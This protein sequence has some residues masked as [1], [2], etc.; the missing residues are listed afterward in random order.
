M[1]VMSGADTFKDKITS[2]QDAFFAPVQMSM[3]VQISTHFN[4]LYFINMLHFNFILGQ[5]K[6][7]MLLILENLILI[8]GYLELL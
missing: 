4:Y 1:F 8:H 6:C 7:L 3:Q 2:P 5:K